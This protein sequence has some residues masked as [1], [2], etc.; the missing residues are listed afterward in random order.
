MRAD[1]RLEAQIPEPTI[2]ETEGLPVHGHDFTDARM[3]S[4]GFEPGRRKR[5]GRGVPEDRAAALGEVWP[6][7]PARLVDHSAVMN[8]LHPRAVL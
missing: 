1:F 3:R 8:K 2:I 5:Q 6:G 4:E 7:E